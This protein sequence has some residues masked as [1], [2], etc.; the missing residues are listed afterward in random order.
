M[1]IEEMLLKEGFTQKEVSVIRQHA[2]KNGYPYPW[3]LSQLKKRFIAAMILI[4]ILLAGLIYTIRSGTQ[5]N[6]VSYS[7]TLLAGFTILYIFIPLK[8]AHK[9]FKF[10]RKHS[11][12]L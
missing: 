9:A 8:P 12:I 10:L 4:A 7:I 11:H 6:L 2:D 5:E 3:L 1:K